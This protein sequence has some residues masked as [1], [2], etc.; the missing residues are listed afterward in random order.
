MNQMRVR[1]DLSTSILCHNASR[2][3]CDESVLSL[4]FLLHQSIF[5]HIPGRNRRGVASSVKLV[6]VRQFQE[7]HQASFSQ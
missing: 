6:L 5:C 7:P 3:S 1:M 4:F 2:V